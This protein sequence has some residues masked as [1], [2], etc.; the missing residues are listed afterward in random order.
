MS[1][2]QPAPPP[3]PATASNPGGCLSGFVLPPLAVLCVG[4]IL[5]FFW[6]NASLPAAPGALAA[7]L[8]GFGGAQAAAPGGTISAIFRPAVQ[9]WNDQ[10]ESW[11]GEAGL[12]SNL[13]ATVMQI[14]SCG[15]PQARSQAGAIG[16]FQ[17]M[18][19]HFS[20]DENPYLPDTNAERGLAYLKRSLQAAGGDVRLALAGYNGGISLIGRPELTWPGETQRYAYWGSGIYA[21]ASAGASESLRLDEWLAAGGASLC[22]EAEASLGLNP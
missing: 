3:E 1:P 20:L 11:S 4:A 15:N 8:T 6:L 18:P 9:Y 5:A 13:V 7:G 19:D 10:L 22:R 12:D 14:E 2:R 21:E 17:V 16:L